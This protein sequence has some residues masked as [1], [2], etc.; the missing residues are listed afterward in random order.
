MSLLIS[1]RFVSQTHIGDQHILSSIDHCTILNVRHYFLKHLWHPVPNCCQIESKIHLIL[2]SKI[3]IQMKT[4]DYDLI[5]L[6]PFTWTNEYLK[7]LGRIVCLAGTHQHNM[8]RMLAYRPYMKA[9]SKLL[10][11]RPSPTLKLLC[12]LRLLSCWSV[13]AVSLL[14]S[15]PW[16]NSTSCLK[17]AYRKLLIH[18]RILVPS[19]SCIYS[20][21][22]SQTS[23]YNI[24]YY[25]S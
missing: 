20:N 6:V 12:I 2:V 17:S 14:F 24:K 11:A 4:Y 25:C 5:K 15:P 19:M 13:R 21:Y 10:S 16:S 1:M 18:V 7:S 22:V 8:Y 3:A 9:Y 23:I